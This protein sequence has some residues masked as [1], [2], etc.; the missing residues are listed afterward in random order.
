[1]HNLQK[2][3]VDE[4]RI[5][6]MTQFFCNFFIFFTIYHKTFLRHTARRS[7]APIFRFVYVERNHHQDASSTGDVIVITSHPTPHITTAQHLAARDARRWPL[8][9]LTAQS[10]SELYPKQRVIVT[11]II[12]TPDHFI[13]ASNKIDFGN[14]ISNVGACVS[15]FMLY[16]GVT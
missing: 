7:R 11:L 9:L 13:V 5:K 1:M 14:W 8:P 6:V 3:E 16:F 2:R 15:L 10:A 12:I 4:N